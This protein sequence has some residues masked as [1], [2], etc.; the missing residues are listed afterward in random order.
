MQEMSKIVGVGSNKDIN[1]TNK[2]EGIKGCKR[3][4]RI[5]NSL[6]KDGA[7]MGS[8]CTEFER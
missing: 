1:G 5:Y 8:T 7:G 3:W 4:V 2:I 6:G